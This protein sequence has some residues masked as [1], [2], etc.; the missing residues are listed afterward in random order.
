L[1]TT[2]DDS[3]GEAFDKIARLLGITAI[4]GEMQ[5]LGEGSWAEKEFRTWDVCFRVCC[6]VH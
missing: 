2:I 4:P 3:V 6:G 1:G 5:A